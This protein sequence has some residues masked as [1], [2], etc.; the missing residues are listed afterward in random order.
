MRHTLETGFFFRF[1]NL[2]RLLD[3]TESVETGIGSEVD[4][5]LELVILS[6]SSALAKSAGG[7]K[8]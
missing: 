6:L 3:S 5:S 1:K 4:A 7:A 2:A 8:R